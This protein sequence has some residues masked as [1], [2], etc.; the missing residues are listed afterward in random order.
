MKQFIPLEDFWND[1]IRKARRGLHLSESELAQR[2]GLSD[3]D[4]LSLERGE[5]NLQHLAKVGEVLH[6]DVGKL[7]TLARGEYH[8]GQLELP[9][10]MVQFSTPWEDFE[11]HSY[12]LWDPESSV[13]RP[14][15]AFDTGSDASEMLVFLGENNLR[16][17]QIFL[18]HG[19][20]DHIFELDRLMEKTCA[21]A[22]I[23]KREEVPGAESFGAGQ[24]FSVGSLRIETRSTW[25]HSP[26]GISYVIYG[27]ACPVAI[28]GDAIFAGS[29]G[30]A[31]PSTS[32]A[33][34]AGISYEA[35][36]TTNRK[37]LLSLPPE[38]ILSPGHGPLTTVALEKAH[39]PF[40]L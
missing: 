33:G 29:M 17:N 21:A 20:G 2:C 16:L 38:T 24:E 36:L 31:M 4:I 1:V 5:E 9:L 19:H 27:L 28:I 34:R 25:G 40:F 6:L 8:P 18:T 13:P 22:W 30:G 12:L 10:G 11:V 26:G 23:G 32:G 14:A 7:L 3:S 15:A 39:N 35:C 37:E